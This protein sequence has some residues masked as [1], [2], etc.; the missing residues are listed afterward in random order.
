MCTAEED[1]PCAE[2]PEVPL[3]DPTPKTR[4]FPRLRHWTKQI[5]VSVVVVVVTLAVLD[6]LLIG[7]GLFPPRYDL[8]DADLG[9]STEAPDPPP[10]DWCFDYSRD[11]RVEY[12]RNQLGIRTSRTPAEI[13][14][15]SEQFIVAAVGDSHSDLC[16]TN[17]ETHQGVL[18]SELTQFGIDSLVLSNGVGRYSPLQ[19]YLLFKRRLEI[20][21]PDALLLNVYTGNDFN[22][23]LRIDDRP[24]FVPA[25]EGYEVRP[26][27][28]YRYYDPEVHYLSRVLFVGRSLTD[29]LG[30]RNLYLRLLFLGKAARREGGGLGSIV[31]YMNDL[32]ESSEPSIGY[33]GALSAQF[34]NQQLYL[35]HFPSAERESLRR[36]EFLMRMIRAENPGLMLIMSPIPSYELVGEEPID[37]ALPETLKRLPVTLEEGIDQEQRLYDALRGF[38]TEEGW[39]FVDNLEA[40]REY[41]GSERLYNDF[42][43]HITV[44]ASRIIGTTQGDVIREQLSGR[45]ASEESKQVPTDG[46]P[47]LLRGG[48]IREDRAKRPVVR[49]STGAGGSARNLH[50]DTNEDTNG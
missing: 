38:S 18:E 5:A 13:Q 50:D 21:E 17:A 20:F 23:I 24:H 39:V 36:M 7:F 42:D 43:Y 34:L 46:N 26:P 31:S 28:W 48:A 32:R 33:A 19:A 2:R 22:D 3:S 35:H 9:W 41:R 40:L 14:A 11:L 44:A 27:T 12:Y 10:L 15:L 49:R 1:S 25:G 47:L 4:S 30:V 45:K 16:M 37:A 29:R 8:G 6:A